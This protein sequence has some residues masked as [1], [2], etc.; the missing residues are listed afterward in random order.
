M[1]HPS[2]NVLLC[3]DDSVTMQTVAEITFRDSEW[4]YLGARTADEAR[5]AA[6][7]SPSLILVDAVMPDG[8]GYEL[9]R[10]L[11]AANHSAIVVMVCGNSESYDEGRGAAAGIDGHIIKPWQTDKIVEQ[12]A[13]LQSAG[14]STCASLTP[15]VNS[16]VF[17]QT[18]SEHPPSGEQQISARPPMVKQAPAR[19]VRL[20]LA[21]QAEA[22]A[23][24]KARILGLSSQQAI[25]LN[26]VSRELLEQIIWE[27]VPDL[28]EAI[29]RECLS[30]LPVKTK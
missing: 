3:V 10:E 30:Q 12:L 14:P 17:E 24:S 26:S 16:S 2:N 28:A 9:A 20:V 13:A 21:N 5:T 1:T 15:S 29:I 8:S 7:K 19:P 25:D 4:E 22:D 23:E 11:K 18:P 27:V 6:S